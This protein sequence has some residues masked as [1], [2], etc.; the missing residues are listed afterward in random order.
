MDIAKSVSDRNLYSND[1]SSAFA[2]AVKFAFNKNATIT[3]ALV[4]IIDIATM[5]INTFRNKC[6]ANAT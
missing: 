2:K 4:L 1:S 6:I 5:Y 3:T